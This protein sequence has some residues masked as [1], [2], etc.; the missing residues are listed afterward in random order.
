M[1]DALGDVYHRPWA[2][3]VV[4]ADLDRRTAQEALDAGVPPKQVWAAV[5]R[6]LELPATKR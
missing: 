1:S 3:Q 4:L 6:A 2:A 5:W